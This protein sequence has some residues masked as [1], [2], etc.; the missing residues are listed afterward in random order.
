[1]TLTMP[2][3]GPRYLGPL[4]APATTFMSASQKRVTVV[5]VAKAAGVALGTV[6]RVLNNFPDVNADIRN[7]VLRAAQDLNYSRIRKRRRST[8]RNGRNGAETTPGV[9]AIMF[10]GMEDAL[11]HLPVVSSALQG[12]E[13]ALSTQHRDLM[14]ANIPEGDRVPPFLRNHRVEG[15]ILKGPNQGLLPPTESNELLREIFRLPYV[16]LMGRLPNATGDHCNFDAEIAGRLVAAHLREKNHRRVAFFNPKPGQSQ[17]ERVKHAFL[18][19]AVPL[20]LEA[21]LLEIE[22]PA[23]LIWPLPAITVEENVDAL[24][25]RWVKLPRTTRPTAL[26]APSD[27]TSV[28]LYASLARRGLRVGHDVSVVS[29]NNERS[30][31]TNLHPALTSVDVQA[32]LIGRRAVD[33]LLWRIAHPNEKL[34]VQLLVEP[35]LVERDSVAK[36]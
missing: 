12:I 18:N 3:V 32:E 21:S 31:A 29:C 26:F 25:G 20:G 17:F 15:L 4:R 2:D 11:V 23:R 36:L 16:W 5:D 35:T 30:L 10:F 33:Q 7:R 1:M 24:V 9:I 28:Q 34:S 19:A 27:R 8:E 6:S 14:F 22:P 13:H